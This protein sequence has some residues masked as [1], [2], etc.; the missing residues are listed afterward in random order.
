[1]CCN[2][3]AM[4]TTGQLIVLLLLFAGI[5]HA[6]RQYES[7]PVDACSHAASPKW[8]HAYARP[9]ATAPALALDDWE[10]KGRVASSALALGHP[11]GLRGMQSTCYVCRALS[12]GMNTSNTSMVVQLQVQGT[13]WATLPPNAP[14]VSDAPFAVGPAVRHRYDFVHAERVCVL[15]SGGTCAAAN[16]GGGGS[17]ASTCAV[18]CWGAG[19]RG[20]PQRTQKGG[21]EFDIGVSRATASGR[22]FTLAG[23]GSGTAGHRDGAA[24]SARFASPEGVAVSAARTVYVADT[25][26]HVIRAIDGVTSVVTT[27]AGVPGVHGYADGA[28]ADARFHS[29]AGIAVLDDCGAVYSGEPQGQ[30]QPLKDLDASECTN[31]EEWLANRQWNVNRSAPATN[32]GGGLPPTAITTPLQLSQLQPTKACPTILIIADTLNHCIRVVDVAGGLVWT[33]AGGGVSGQRRDVRAAEVE[34]R[35]GGSVGDARDETERIWATATRRGRSQDGMAAAD[36]AVD[37]NLEGEP[38]SCADERRAQRHPVAGYAD[39]VGLS[40]RFDT[41]VSVAVDGAGTVF[42]ADMRNSL[43]R[44]VTAQERRVSTL[45]G[46]T[47]SPTHALPGYPFPRLVGTAGGTDARLLSGATFFAPVSVAVG[48]GS[49]PYA[50]VVVDANRVRMIY[51]SGALTSPF[52]ASPALGGPG[53][54]STATL[55]ELATLD[56]VVTLA[57]AARAGD[58]D[59]GTNESRLDMPR[60]VAV[61]AHGRIYVADSLRCRLRL[62]TA[63]ALAAVRAGC[64]T[65]A[66]DLVRPPGCASRDAPVDVLGRIVSRVVG[67]TEL[68]VAADANASAVDGDG[69]A[70]P[71]DGRAIPYCLGSPPPFEGTTST[72]EP[73]TANGVTGAATAPLLVDEDTGQGTRVL[74]ACPG[75]C[76]VASSAQVL[77]GNGGF[78]DDG[79]SVCLAAIHAGALD[80]NVGGVVAVVFASNLPRFRRNSWLAGSAGAGGVDSGDA[81][82]PSRVFTVVAV[83]RAFDHVE[84]TTL[85]GA[86]AASLDSSCG[87]VD[88]APPTAAA[89]RAPVGI[90]LRRDAVLSPD[91]L[92]VVADAANH[93]IRGITAAC[94]APCENGGVC[95]STETCTCAPGWEGIDCT[96]ALCAN[97]ACGR[98]QLCTAPDTCTC[99]PG[100]GGADCDEA[101]CAVPCLNGGACVAPDACACAAGWFGTACTVP[102]CAHT[103]GNGGDCVAPDIC[104]CP[105]WWTGADCRTPVCPQGCANGGVCAAPQSCVCTPSWSGHDCSKPV[106]TQGFFRADPTPHSAPTAAG[107]IR[108]REWTQFV[109]C[110]YAAW[111]AATGEFECLQRQRVLRSVPLPTDRI[112]T[113]FPRSGPTW[114]SAGV[115][116]GTGPY[117]VTRD[118]NAD[119]SDRSSGAYVDLDSSAVAP[120][121]GDATACLGLELAL[122]A[123]VVPYP[124]ELAAGGAAARSP[125]LTHAARRTPVTP[126]DV[127]LGFSPLAWSPPLSSRALPDRQVAWVVWAAVTQGVYVC[128]NGGNCT[129]PDYCVCAPGWV[130]FDCRTPVCAQGF[131]Y[132]RDFGG[133]G[134]SY[135]NPALPEQG[136]YVASLR[137]L[138]LWERPDTPG[139]KFD[140]Y[141]HDHPN[142]HSSAADQD[143][144]VGL[145]TAYVLVPGPGND[146]NEGWRRDGWWQRFG[147]AFGGLVGWQAGNPA[148]M[149]ALFNRTC[150]ESPAKAGIAGPV[151]DSAVAHSAVIVY[152]PARVA[153]GSVPWWAEAGGECVDEVLHGCFNGGVCTAPNVCVCAS[154]WIGVDCTLPVCA[155]STGNVTTAPPSLYAATA[156]SSAQRQAHL[157]GGND[158]AP[159]QW[160]TCAHSGNCTRPSV[161]T[162]EKGWGGADCMTALCAQECFHG[163]RC[164]APDVCTCPQWPSTAVDARG[165]PLYRKP[166]GA[167]Q[168]TGW[169]GYDCGTPICVLAGVD[170][171]A[172]DNTG[173]RIVRLAATTNDGRAFEG[174][175]GAGG[176]GAAGSYA[177]HNSSRVSPDFLC[178]VAVWYQGSYLESWANDYAASGS[179]TP[180][181]TSPGRYAR[182]NFP[183][184][185][186]PPRGVDG[187]VADW[188]AGSSIAGEGLYACAH[189]G[190]CIA[191]DLCICAAGWGDRDCL[192]PVC[193]FASTPDDNNDNASAVTVVAECL[194]GGVCIAPDTCACTVGWAGIRCG[195]PTCSQGTYIATCLIL[196]NGTATNTGGSGCWMCANGGVC[197]APDVCS[198]AL[199][200]AGFDCATPVCE[201]FADDGIIAE[202]HA[203]R[204]ATVASFEVDPCRASTS[205]APHGVCAAPGTCNCACVPGEPW[206][207]PLHR[208]LPAGVVYGSGGCVSGWEGRNR[209]DGTF[210]S[211]HLQIFVPSWVERNT[212]TL[213]IASSCSA[214]ALALLALVLYRRVRARHQWHKAARR[215]A[216]RIEAAAA[217]GG[218][219]GDVTAAPTVSGGAAA[220]SND[221]LEEN[222]SSANAG[223]GD[224]AAASVTPLPETSV[225]AQQ[226]LV[227]KRYAGSAFTFS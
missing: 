72:G 12:C 113:G 124:L 119:C 108:P 155:A 129:A 182:L 41:P 43:I 117:N 28:T 1:M 188:V 82:H 165:I 171:L 36:T 7:A 59:G 223:D 134:P 160:F 178:G 222:A 16:I 141:M 133:D 63:L 56:T 6:W 17:N 22:V 70:L 216:R 23:D 209:G 191:P 225:T 164:T 200:W 107:A 69:V 45:A 170:R 15:L 14:T 204:R 175:C 214:A 78:Y 156:L 18:R 75:G 93:A 135:A 211:C 105:Q 219:G 115:N 163:G 51:A 217:V 148:V 4:R 198:C 207:D 81:P 210:A 147:T 40:A 139:R 73:S 121:M 46:A 197:V 21:W 35:G 138:T 89:F 25:G 53:F 30:Q 193:A 167:A 168:D 176:D 11:C 87:Y 85:A 92:L 187:D 137:T 186:E 114:L 100:Y 208:Q 194:N 37:V 101:Q 143:A 60:G 221:T 32:G 99:T 97:G 212:V 177:P 42:V 57:G 132:P 31:G 173:Q 80:R 185:D 33:L 29:P 195:E 38:T 215:R 54:S 149:R 65:R 130:G 66:I 162:C 157:S 127:P 120:P 64:D 140:A 142:F 118:A 181:F 218:R 52:A 88:G 190:S 96:V 183:N 205:P 206:R 125:N 26:N 67:A 196:Q 44:M 174:G 199:G 86:A 201:L 224:S 104:A 180:S 144:H 71:L 111:C 48:P 9:P 34:D 50:L 158:G 184:F 116:V 62:V 145:P 213:I 91:E 84:V 203:L 169:T 94:T 154:G 27:V 61:D 122:D 83:A 74:I 76:A 2:V 172:N 161:C 179:A 110:G 5:A 112:V 55:A 131:Y 146:T 151:P 126:Y 166:D 159:V 227:R 102:V 123:S 77:G 152:G 202:L 79:S 98:R 226:A 106:C 8:P 19:S 95:S 20:P 153:L 103:C 90:A 24:S 13:A 3:N 39:G 68:N 192:I 220:H 136:Q 47:G 150:R 49:A 10:R 128:A 58:E 189:G 109:P